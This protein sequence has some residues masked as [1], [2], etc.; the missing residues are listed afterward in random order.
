MILTIDIGNTCIVTGLFHG[1]KLLFKKRQSTQDLFNKEQL[2]KELNKALKKENKTYDEIDSAIISS[3]VPNLT[4]TVKDAVESITGLKAKIVDLKATTKIDLSVYNENT[5]GADRIADMVGA[6]TIVK[7][8][9]LV[10]DIGTATTLS[11]V[12]KGYRFEGGFI[13]AGMKMSLKALAENTAKLP[14]IEPASVSDFPGTTTESAILSGEILGTAA[15]IDGIASLLE[16]KYNLN[17]ITIVLTGG[18]SHL[19]APHIIHS[20]VYEKNLL[21]YGLKAIAEAD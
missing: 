10:C 2:T 13:K 19:V 20:M 18:L 15:M 9:F 21:L 12:N 14:Q 8:P 16:N 17:N 4:K 3:V 6:S 11:F 7:P 1:E 5:L